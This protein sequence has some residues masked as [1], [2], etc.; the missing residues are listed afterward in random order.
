[1]EEKIMS[2]VN[3]KII[4]ITFSILF[5]SSF[6]FNIF[7][8]SDLN[9]NDSFKTD[10]LYQ[11]IHPNKFE[12]NMKLNT[13][14]NTSY[15]GENAGDYAGYSVS[16]A[17]DVNGDGYDD[18]LIGAI[19]NKDGSGAF[20]GKTYLIFGNITGWN[21]NMTLN[22]TAN[23]SFIGENSEDYSGCSVSGAGDVNG[24][25][26]ADIL[27]GALNND[28]G[29]GINA[30][31]T[32]LIFGKSSGWKINATLNTTAN[33]SFIGENNGD[34]S[35]CSVSGAGDV[36]GDGYD[37]ILIGA[38]Y[39]GHGLGDRYG[40]T[41]L[42]FGKSSGWKVNATLNT[43]ANASF[44]GENDEDHSGCSVS[45]AGDVNG[46]GYDDIL[47][48]AYQGG[49]DF[50]GETYLIL[51]KNSGWSIDSSLS[52]ADAS[53]IGE[54]NIDYSGISVSIAGDVNGDEYDDILIGAYYHES[55]NAFGETY[56]IL[57]K[58]LG[59]SMDSSLSTAD[60]SFE[61]EAYDDF[62]GYSVSD[63]GDINGDGYDDILIGAYGRNANL[64]TY[65]GE[66]YL[67]LGND[68]DWSMGASLSSAHAS[69]EGEA[70]G[71][72]SGYSVSGAGDVNGDGYDDILIGAYQYTCGSDD[73]V[74]KTYMLSND[75]NKFPEVVNSIELEQINSYIDYL[76]IRLIGEDSSA[77]SIDLAEVKIN[78]TTDPNG[79]EL[80]LIETGLNTGI[81]E[82]KVR[83][84]TTSSS[85][86]SK[87]L[88]INYND[89]ID[90]IY[91]KNTSNNASI[92]I[93]TYHR[94]LINGNDNFTVPN[95]VINAS[96]AGTE[97]DPFIIGNWT[98]DGNN[99]G[100]CIEIRDTTKFF[101]IYNCSLLNGEIGIKLENVTNGNIINN[102]FYDMV[103]IDG[104][105]GENGGL[106]TAIY[107]SNSSLNNIENNTIYN[108]TSGDGGNGLSNQPGWDGGI[109]TGIYFRNSSLNSIKNNT[110][111]E[112][113]G[114]LGGDGGDTDGS[115]GSGGFGI[116]IYL[117]DSC[118]NDIQN[119]SVNN[120]LGGQ[121][122]VG[123]FDLGSGGIGGISAG[124]YLSNSSHN[125]IDNNS[126]NNLTSGDGGAAVSGGSGG[127]SSG[128][129]FSKSINN[130]IDN[131]SI[132][133]LTGGQGG[134]S[135][136]DGLGFGLYFE[137]DSYENRI[138][139][140]NNLNEKRIIYLFNHSNS[141]I[142]D[143]ILTDQNYPTN[144]GKIVLINCRNMS[145]SDNKISNFKGEG[146]NTGH[147]YNSGTNGKWGAGIYI[148]NSQN[149]TINNN[150][151]ENIKGGKCGASGYL[152]E[153]GSGGNGVGI[154]LHNS[155]NMTIKNN[156]INNID[157]GEGEIS[158]IAS[159]S[160][161]GY[162]MGI[163]LNNSYKNSLINNTINNITGGEGGVSHPYYSGNDGIGIYLLNSTNNTINQNQMDNIYG[164]FEEFIEQY[165]I[166]YQGSVGIGVGIF[167]NNDS[168]E[169]VIFKNN[170][171]SDDPILYFYQQSDK[172]IEDYN[173]SNHFNPTNLG[174]IVFINCSGFELKNNN[175]SNYQGKDAYWQDFFDK[176][177]ANGY[178]ATG[179]YMLNSINITV[180]NN[181][182]SNITGGNGG[183]GGGLDICSESGGDGGL[184]V[185]FYLNNSSKITFNNNMIYSMGGGNGGTGGGN[186]EGSGG[187]GGMGIGF[188]FSNS[189]NNTLY[190]N[191][192]SNIY[193]GK[194]GIGK[195][196]ANDG[197]MGSAFSI[198]F[199]KDS[200]QNSIARNNTIDN[201]PIIY[202][203]NESDSII[204][205]YNISGITNP[206]N[207]GKFIL[208][209]CR[210]ITIENN[211]IKNFKGK[212]GSSGSTG[213]YGY[214]ED[215]DNG[216]GIFCLDSYNISII[217]NKIMNITGG[218]GGTCGTLSGYAKAY[219]GLAIGIYLSNS[220]NNSIRDNTI[221]NI[222]GGNGG[223]GGYGGVG[224]FGNLGVGIYFNTSTNNTI[225]NNSVINITG[226]ER[227]I[228]A[229]G[230]A[231]GYFNYAA[232]IYINNSNNNTLDK[233]IALDIQGSGGLTGYGIYFDHSNG[234][235]VA[236]IMYDSEF[237]NPPDEYIYF[238]VGCINNSYIYENGTQ[239]YYYEDKTIYFELDNFPNNDTLLIYYR[240]NNGI[241]IELNVTGTHNYTFFADNPLGVLEWY[242]WFNDTDGHSWN[243]PTLSFTIGDDIEPTFSNL[244]EI[245]LLE[246]G[247]MEIIQ[248]N[249]SD[250]SLSDVLI[251]FGNE[252]H[253]MNNI[254]GNIWNYSWVPNTIGELTYTVY[255]NDTSGNWNSISDSFTIQDTK[256]PEI[257]INPIV[258]YY[259]NS[260]PIFNVEF[261]DYYS[262]DAGYF[263]I[264]TF[265][266]TR[267]NTT[268]WIEIFTDHS[269]N[270]YTLDVQI[271]SGI[272]D[273]LNDGIHTIYFKTWDD[274]ENIN[275]G[276]TPSWQ[277]YKD[278]SIEKPT[279]L[280]ILIN[281]GLTQNCCT[282]RWTNP[283]DS[284]GIVGAYYKFNTA[285]TSNFDGTY[286]EE[287]DINEIEG[288]EAPSNGVHIIYI[289]LKDLAGN[290]NYSNYVNTSINFYTIDPENYTWNIEGNN[291]ILNWNLLNNYD[292][293]HY[294]VYR[295]RNPIISINSLSP[296]VS[297]NNQVNS[298][299][300]SGLEQAEY[301]YIITAQCENGQEI[302]ISHNIN[303]DLSTT[304]PGTNLISD[305]IIFLLLIIFGILSIISLSV[306][307]IMIKK[308]IALKSSIT[309]IKS[310]MYG[311]TKKI[312]KIKPIDKKKNNDA[313]NINKDIK[314]QK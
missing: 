116:G 105:T 130:T 161:G 113:I 309:E 48:G 199:E 175:I 79:I 10:N 98:I 100:I 232:G 217:N 216:I 65:Q 289:W 86:L 239:I 183:I 204:K 5:L 123:G 263:Q 189:I 241:W 70:S 272:W 36:N 25:G 166:E 40:K 156:T 154:Y 4:I 126:I 57:G 305:Q 82:G 160:T 54:S 245:D 33:A 301:F 255:A 265:I 243:T 1:M 238:K 192:I 168:Y 174:K 231:P 145:I 80:K 284:S 257:V 37:D 152:S 133:N 34:N 308:Y 207:L 155:F 119:N 136:A 302:I 84:I 234:S 211:I 283:T 13:I 66:T 221:N 83:L 285:P 176:E 77:D 186:D 73:N 205:N 72:Y 171:I 50:H 164:G 253:T 91:K 195:P 11:E 101:E 128:I 196:K 38:N 178:N 237:G 306:T 303:V 90:V 8:N 107:G 177:S 124:I 67:I 21:V 148:L 39:G 296:I 297:L 202:L 208:I 246:I 252:N 182:I 125:L 131:N 14:S 273:S 304:S 240:L 312:S 271:P 188:Y 12:Q 87:R 18:I 118:F 275:D 298:Y 120:I 225:F 293:D 53:F 30:G 55:E 7:Q 44:V 117:W 314:N 209:N 111:N 194:S 311:K 223:D 169:N 16:G 250:F 27:I 81:Y 47:I 157:G 187:A 143:Y 75:L 235:M 137:S 230:G 180:E 110:I 24:D 256:A 247:N 17:G 42:I 127:V 158:L 218:Q 62:S 122:G 278:A 135:S 228:A 191:N 261:F 142:S 167:L 159:I 200:Y 108:L 307:T 270:S 280:T 140:L 115:G 224:G 299:T 49:L 22:S 31:K 282:I 179:V 170:T 193:G 251:E 220:N 6:L 139:E 181:I 2:R 259:F 92:F 15:I 102:S 104:T 88:K 114:G 292:V 213:Y 52:S 287:N 227:G 141:I 184:G 85:E 41:Y 97:E 203:F 103:G 262:L 269:S 76:N 146:G 172:T 295:S 294:H 254:G 198:Y 290:I 249:V 291:V 274:E 35:G 233:N 242:L 29:T 45:G 197:V 94:I 206:T 268:D 63:A 244:T 288:I 226:G 276:D 264:D 150:T 9:N 26:Y 214:G 60:A 313:G 69:F 64:G 185:G 229:E 138:L 132:S 215:A 61:G 112:I 43:T 260:S 149:C 20:T 190:H 59:W 19:S 300:D 56:L 46:D 78:S 266:P 95:G 310:N 153:A 248:I 74:G 32:Y 58:S 267:I 279:G 134:G 210:N 162:A 106:S 144:L 99:S 212:G 71:D 222:T 23:A 28:D 93:N 151:V 147:I 51:G 3:Q 219:G 163:N 96:A 277:F 129:Y 201:V 121:G 165:E 89:E 286:V 236:Y 258:E 68:S 109:S 173:I 281:N